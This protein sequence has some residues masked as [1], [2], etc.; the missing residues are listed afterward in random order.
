MNGKLTKEEIQDCRAHIVT[1][2]KVYGPDRQN[3][4]EGGRKWQLWLDA[5]E[6]LLS[7]EEAQR[8]IFGYEGYYALRPMLPE[9]GDP[10]TEPALVGEYSSDNALMSPDELHAFLTAKIPDVVGQLYL[11]S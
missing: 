9:L 7:E 2:T 8:T 4:P 10:V 6:A 3:W 5:H 11:E 1:L